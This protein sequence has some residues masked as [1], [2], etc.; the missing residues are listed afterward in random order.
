MAFQLDRSVLAGI[1][2]TTLQTWLLQAQTALQ[3]LKVG[4]LPQTVTVTGGGQHREVTFTKA[5]VG[6]L[7]Q[8]ILELQAA[9]GMRRKARRAFT[10]RFV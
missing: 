4:G 9:L 3:N 5:S 8:W 7:T 6:D 10:F 2:P 1:D